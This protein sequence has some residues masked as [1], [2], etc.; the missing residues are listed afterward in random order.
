MTQ[1]KHV[2]SP[3][4]AAGERLTASKRESLTE[5]RYYGNFLNGY[6]QADPEAS[7]SRPAPSHCLSVCLPACLSAVGEPVGGG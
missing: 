5:Y 2:A 4:T 6:L 7:T 3:Q 1:T